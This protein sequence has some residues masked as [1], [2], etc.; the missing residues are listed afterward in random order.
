MTRYI[1]N[2]AGTYLWFWR[3]INI[4]ILGI[5]LGAESEIGNLPKLFIPSS[6]KLSLP[7]APC[8]DRQAW[9]FR[10]FS[11]V[12]PRDSPAIDSLQSRAAMERAKASRQRQARACGAAHAGLKRLSGQTLREGRVVSLRDFYGL[13][14]CA[15]SGFCS[16]ITGL[17]FLYLPATSWFRASWRPFFR[18]R[19]ALLSA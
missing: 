13:G 2:S 1:R 6:A 4:C 15:S 11:S 8:C 14:S 19:I 17:C 3:P 12:S 9:H 18:S 16:P 5:Y 7:V 10:F